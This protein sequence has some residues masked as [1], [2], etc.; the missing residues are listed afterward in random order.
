MKPLP[1]ALVLAGALPFMF[2]SGSLVLGKPLH[3]T[4][5]IVTLLTYGAVILSFLGGIQWGIA[6][7]IADEAPTSA[8]RLF[9]LS[10]LPSLAAWATLLLMNDPTWQLAAQLGILIAVWAVD[11]LLNLQRI[12]P[13]G[14]FK[15]R[16]GI[17]ALVSASYIVALLA[18]PR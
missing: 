16:T 18:L 4:V 5:A 9:V 6:L 11:G 14:F 12:L 3:P 17:T 13:A 2:A 1:V 8:Q 15:L 10:V 7:R